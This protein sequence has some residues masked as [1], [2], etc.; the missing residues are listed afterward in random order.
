VPLGAPTLRNLLRGGQSNNARQPLPGARQKLLPFRHAPAR[1]PESSRLSRVLRRYLPRRYSYFGMPAVLPSIEPS[2]RRGTRYGPPRF[3]E[4]FRQTLE[5]HVFCADS[6]A[7]SEKTS[8]AA[9]SIVAC[10]S[11]FVNAG[12]PI[13][14]GR[15]TAEFCAVSTSEKPVARDERDSDVPIE[16]AYRQKG[17]PPTARATDLI[18]LTELNEKASTRELDKNAVSNFKKFMASDAGARALYVDLHGILTHPA[19]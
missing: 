13:V 12:L 8:K 15:S 4:A 11:K 9:Y 17:S 1:C 19:Q 6:S 5:S 14:Q 2:K 18:M 7:A 16:V 10:H 3:R